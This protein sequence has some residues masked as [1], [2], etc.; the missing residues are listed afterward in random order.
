MLNITYE[1]DGKIMSAAIKLANNPAVEV[2]TFEKAGL[3]ITP[4]I[5]AFRKSWLNSKASN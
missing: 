3:T 4:Q 1:R 2:V 5:E